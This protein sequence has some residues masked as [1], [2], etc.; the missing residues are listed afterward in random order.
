MT[1]MHLLLDKCY[2]RMLA[3][4]EDKVMPRKGRRG[5]NKLFLCIMSCIRGLGGDTTRNSA[6]LNGAACIF[7]HQDSESKSSD[8][9]RV[10][11]CRGGGGEERKRKR[12]W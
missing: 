10:M 7:V 1:D 8:W 3:I 11:V 4:M 2:H 9:F 6:Q 5:T 12:C